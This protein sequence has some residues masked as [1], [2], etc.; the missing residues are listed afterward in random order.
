MVT[1]AKSKLNFHV[2]FYY[3]VLF[4]KSVVNTEIQL[5]NKEPENISKSK[6]N[7]LFKKELKSLLLSHFFY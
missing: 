1:Y 7:K 3:T 5:Y 4:K 6:S 2:Q